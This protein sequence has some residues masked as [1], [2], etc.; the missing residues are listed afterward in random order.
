MLL[1]SSAATSLENLA[2]TGA[3][4]L[5]VTH[6][7]TFVSYQ[8][9][10]RAV[11]VEPPLRRIASASTPSARVACS[12]PRG[13][14][15]AEGAHLAAPAPG[16]RR[17]HRGRRQ[18]VRPDAGAGGG[19]ASSRRSRRAYERLREHRR[20]TLC[21]I[22]SCF[23]GVVPAEIATASADG[24]PNVTHLSRVHMVDDEH[25]A[26]SNQFFS[27]TVRNLAEN[28]RACVIVIDPLT[29]RQLQADPAVRAHRA[30]RPAVRADATRHRRHRRAHGHAGRLQAPQRRRVPRRLDRPGA[31]G[32]ARATTANRR[33]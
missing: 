18:R 13:R 6:F 16:H 28:P 20:I 23:E 21:D 14:R 3:F 11:R 15:H 27:K 4:A 12:D 29:L 2:T 5:T 9:K 26:L 19:G 25:V 7:T 24:I 1:S 31:R 17:V 22:A 30:T 8:L 32:A 10:G 33:A